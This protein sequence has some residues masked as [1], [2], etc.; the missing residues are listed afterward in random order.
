MSRLYMGLFVGL[1]GGSAH[2]LTFGV[3]TVLD[4]V[5]SNPGDGLASDSEGRTSLRSAIEESVALGGLHTINFD[6]A[7]IANGDQIITLSEKDTGQDAG[8]LG[9]TAFIL[10]N[11]TTV[12]INGPSGD[13]GITVERTASSNTLFR[14]FHVQTGSALTINNL[15]LGNG[16]AVG[17]STGSRTASGG[18]G[19]GLGGG[20]LNEGTVTLEGVTLFGNSATG[21]AGGNGG[22]ASDGGAGGGGAAG[23][24]GQSSNNSGGT[25]G[26][27]GGGKGGN[28]RSG[29]GTGSGS[30]GGSGGIFGGAGGGGGSLCTGGGSGTCTGGNGGTGGF[31]GGGG[32]GGSV[33]SY[34]YTKNI[35]N[36]GSGG[37]GGGNGTNGRADRNSFQPSG[38]GGGG[39]A[40]GGTIFN[41]GGSL[42]VRNSTISGSTTSGGDSG[43]TSYGSLVVADGGGGD[44]FGGAI[45]SMNNSGTNATVDLR[46]VTVT[47]TTVIGGVSNLSAGT[48]DGAIYIL[49]NNGT[50]TAILNNTIV[51]NTSTGDDVIVNTISGGSATANGQGNLIESHTGFTGSI[52]VTSNPD[53]AALTDNR[54]PTSTH[55]LNDSSPA[56]DAGDSA[57]INGLVTDQRGGIFNRVIDGDLNGSTLV[58]I[59]AYELIQIDYG[60]APDFVTGTGDVEVLLENGDDDFRISFAGIDGSTATQASQPRVA[61]NETADEFL[62]VWTN[63]DPDNEYEIWGQRVNA[64]TRQMIGTQFQISAMNVDRDA[65]R[66]DVSWSSATNE[67]LV[68]W[69]GD[70]VAATDNKVEIFGRFISATGNLLE[71]QLR[72]SQMGSDNDVLSRTSNSKVAYSS[73][74]NEFLVVWDGDDAVSPTLDNENEI[75]GQRYAAATR[76]A[77]GGRMQISTMGGDSGVS[78]AYRP[79]KPQITWN[80]ATNNYFVVWESDDNANGSI[81]NEIEIFGRLVAGGGVPLGT[82]QTRLTTLGGTGNTASRAS[83]ADVAYN[84]NNNQF[85]VTFNGDDALVS[86]NET[87]IFGQ[88]VTASTGQP[89]GSYFKI[90]DVGLSES[91]SFFGSTSAVA[92]NPVTG[93]Y[94]VTFYG[95]EK[96]DNEHEIW[97]RRV[98]NLGNVLDS[99]EVR[100]T[101]MGPDGVTTFGAFNSAIAYSTI[102]SDFLVVYRADDDTPP[103]IDGEIEI[104]G[105]FVTDTK[106]VDYQTR[107]GDNGPAHVLVPGMSL[108]LL[109]DNDPDGLP[110]VDAD[111][112]DKDN[113]D[114]EDALSGSIIEFFDGTTPVLSVNVTNT[115]GSAATLYGWIDYNADGVFDNTSERSSISVPNGTN[116]ENL[117]LTMPTPPIDAAILTMSRFRLSSD[118]MA[119]NPTGLVTG[120]EIED[121]LVVKKIDEIYK[122]GFE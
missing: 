60:D 117:N 92:Y 61:Y 94:S 55:A 59:G 84:P 35:G 119:A 5:D 81:D 33:V 57:Q 102:S 2:A 16:S 7:L 111:G 20:I 97:V 24:G 82:T 116:A 69:D 109:T 74:S 48:G 17:G 83:S 3:N 80:S 56:I 108:G 89:V 62:V 27:G 37:F 113:I 36:G 105:Q 75:W 112:D 28:G 46:H 121:Y 86:D 45:F 1:F 63:E 31:G 78:I 64:A 79:S 47:D 70:N 22:S 34:N 120:G 67:Y 68:V 41:Y 53:L 52:N 91:T 77:S 71:S 4:T 118:P 21:G 43:L 11:N 114:D 8:E 40:F 18:G 106:L 99:D 23:N 25:G 30:T 39:A 15:A 65:F 73:T 29:A 72:I 98:D 122:D 95:D 110:S 100:L 49:G 14:L 19:A 104:F 96:V 107:G 103:L 6:A 101:N 76:T 93:N 12:T 115:S 32:G 38:D 44:G 9:A 90:S 85:L 54:G 10:G 87:E 26:I 58:D 42:T 13:N 50:S 66:A 88:F 51:A